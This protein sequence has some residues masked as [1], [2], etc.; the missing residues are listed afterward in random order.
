MIL[1]FHNGTGSIVT[2][3]KLYPILEEARQI[4]ENEIIKKREIEAKQRAADAESARRTAA[5]NK[6]VKKLCLVAAAVVIIIAIASAII[7]KTN[8]ASIDPSL[9]NIQSTTILAKNLKCHKRT[10]TRHG[11]SCHCS[12][13]SR[14]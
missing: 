4:R 2:E 12:S 5:R 3:E 1:Y 11:G 9:V 8:N 7:T 10:N 6:L 13:R 14:I